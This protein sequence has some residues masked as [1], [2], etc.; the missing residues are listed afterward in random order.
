MA[1]VKRI[2]PLKIENEGGEVVEKEVL[3]EKLI[4][5]ILF[6]FGGIMKV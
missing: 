3:K 5:V 4:L 6:R 1:I 2:E